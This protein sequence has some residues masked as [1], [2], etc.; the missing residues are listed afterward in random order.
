MGLPFKRVHDGRVK[1]Q[2]QEHLRAHISDFSRRQTENSPR[3]LKTLKPVPR[4]T[5]PTRPNLLIFLK[6]FHKL[7]TKDS[8]IRAYGCYSH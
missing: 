4:D 1:V 5:P 8:N 2:I 3:L 7:G 6:Q